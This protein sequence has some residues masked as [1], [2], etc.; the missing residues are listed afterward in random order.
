MNI[1]R[2]LLPFMTMPTPQL[3]KLGS[4][5][6]LGWESHNLTRTIKKAMYIRVSDPFLN[7]NIGKYQLSNILDEVFFSPLDLQIK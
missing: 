6:I 1:L 2:H 7:R 3:P 5:S 4:L